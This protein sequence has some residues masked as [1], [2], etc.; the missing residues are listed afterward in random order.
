MFPQQDKDGRRSLPPVSQSAS[1]LPLFV[2][3]LPLCPAVY[4]VSH[5]LKFSCQEVCKAV[6]FAIFCL[7]VYFNTVVNQGMRAAWGQ[8]LASDS[9]NFTQRSSPLPYIPSSAGAFTRSNTSRPAP[10]T[11]MLHVQREGG[12]VCFTRK[13]HTGI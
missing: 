5:I 12:V 9:H 13:T 6:F 8:P 11:G 7:A 1:E 3:S 10:M 4:Q 2:G